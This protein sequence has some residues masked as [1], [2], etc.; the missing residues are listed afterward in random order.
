MKKYDIQILFRGK[1]YHFNTG[2]EA[3]FFQTGINNDVQK[4]FGIK[5]LLE[6]VSKAYRCYLDDEHHTPLSDLGDFVA[7]HYTKCKKMD[8]E[9]ILEWF[10][11]N[12]YY[13]L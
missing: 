2:H 13:I 10:Y 8:S 1:T 4:K 7:R 11:E 5:G 12:V 9:Q 6:Y 3:M